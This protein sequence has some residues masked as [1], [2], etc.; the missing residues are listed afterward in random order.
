MQELPKVIELWHTL[1]IRQPYA[2]IKLTIQ[3]KG[4]P[5]SQEFYKKVEIGFNKKKRRA[6]IVSVKYVLERQNQY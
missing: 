4:I 1:T 2:S 3:A 6:S 5:P